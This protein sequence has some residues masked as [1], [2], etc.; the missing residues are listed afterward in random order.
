MSFTL[1]CMVLNLTTLVF[2]TSLLLLN[3]NNKNNN[4]TIPTTRSLITADAEID[5][6]KRALFAK[7]LQVKSLQS[8]LERAKSDVTLS[9]TLQ[10]RSEEDAAEARRRDVAALAGEKD[11]LLRETEDTV[12]ALRER[13]GME[14]ERLERERHEA[15]G[16]LV[17]ERD[18]LKDL[19]AELRAGIEYLANTAEMYSVSVFTSSIDYT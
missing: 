9:R 13:Y 8:E 6:L 2:P 11:T 19:V 16:H 5:L 17:A 7:G 15:V 14:M 4:T 18:E 3:N 1:L 12:S 10:K